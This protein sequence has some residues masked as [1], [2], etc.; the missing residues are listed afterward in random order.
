MISSSI[1]R[2]I[3]T[4]LAYHC[5]GVVRF[6]IVA[7]SLLLVWP[8]RGNAQNCVAPALAEMDRAASRADTLALA[9]R[10]R[11]NPPGGERR[12]GE[13]L[14]AVLQGL[15]STPAEGEWQ[16]RQ[17]AADL[18]ESAMRWAG[19]EP[20]LYLALANL[21]YNRQART[22]AVRMLDR[23]LERRDHDPALRPR[24]VAFAH[25][26]RGLMHADEWRSWRSYGQI[27]AIG[28][29]QWRCGRSQ[30]AEAASFSSSSSDYTWLVAVNQMCGDRFAENM[31]AYFKPLADLKRDEVAAMEAAFA[32]AL[33]A[34]STY[35][36]PAQALLAE[37]V[38]LG[39]WEKSREAARALQRRR[40]DDYQ[41]Y[42]YLGLVEHESGNDSLAAVEFGRALT[43]MPDSVLS[44]FEDIRMLLVPGQI[45]WLESQDQYTQQMFRA[46]FWTTLDP[47]YLT[48]ANE[49]KL[50]HYARLVAADLMFTSPAL[51]ERG[52]ASFAGQIWIRYGRPKH[53][54]EL[55]EPSGRVIF[56]DLGPGPDVA[57]LRGAGYRSYRPFDEAVEFANKLAQSSPQIYN[58]AGLFEP[59][60]PL[61]AQVVRFL[62][63]RGHHELMVNGAWPDGL[64]AEA[65]A[66]L[67]LLDASYQPVAQWRGNVSSDSGLS[68]SV[69]GMAAG[70]Y[71]LTVEVW[72][73][74]VRRLYR[75]RDTV[76]TLPLDDSTFV[77]SDLLLTGA[78]AAPDDGEAASR[79]QLGVTPLFGQTLT[80]GKAVGLV[81]E[82]YRLT[83][84]RDGR[85]RYHV[86]ISVLDAGRQPVSTRLLRGLGL[87]GEPRAQAR[88]EYDGDRPL[89]NGRTVDWV[90]LSGELGPGQ[91]RIVLRLVDEKTGREV[92]RE[93]ELRV[94]APGTD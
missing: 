47:L 39:D 29:G 61:P 81:W 77:A 51:A 56:W 42:L 33:E 41:T 60:A 93:R 18:V 35:L 58:T 20:R 32:R 86:T 9:Q 2:I 71:S 89:V 31:A 13:L 52:S 1:G 27:P 48:S 72:D 14:A 50:E 69:R 28:E 83:G 84:E 91:Y 19:D 68:R 85:M 40:P 92:V 25:Y 7:V 54:W 66:G 82:T 24:E 75:L 94:V 30:G 79:M 57:F 80:A 88:V 74:A 46:A 87:A 15:G 90:E 70:T 43:R 5:G 63:E 3:Q 37:W 10:F 21:M 65:D 23:A 34:D 49:R 64:T 62:D 6:F 44:A 45:T 36:L 59:P 8:A 17:R 73:R 67:T 78:V 11:E 26:L 16:S 12:C 22:D 55:S 53:M 4:G 76:T 38:Y